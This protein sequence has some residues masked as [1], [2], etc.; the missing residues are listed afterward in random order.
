MNKDHVTKEELKAALVRQGELFDMDFIARDAECGTTLCLC[1][2]ALQIAGY[3]LLPAPPNNNGVRWFDDN[4]QSNMDSG[5]RLLGLQ[6]TAMFLVAQWPGPLYNAW[7]HAKTDADRIE[8]GLKA[9]DHF[10]GED[11]S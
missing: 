4:V 2:L 10:M 5:A 6:N 7:Y 1:G 9:I 3:P 8:I 11:K